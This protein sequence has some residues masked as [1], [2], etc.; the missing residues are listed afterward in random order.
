MVRGVKMGGGGGQGARG[1]LVKL[2]M[3]M[4]MPGIGQRLSGVAVFL[5]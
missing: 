3:G 5:L 4:G 2:G 1:I